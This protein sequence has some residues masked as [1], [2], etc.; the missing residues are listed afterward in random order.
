MTLEVS[1]TKSDEIFM[2]MEKVLQ[3]IEI[4][5]GWEFAVAEPVVPN[6]T[7]CLFYCSADM[8]I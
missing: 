5:T 7:T 1:D 8:H 6:D 3:F 2:A 4:S